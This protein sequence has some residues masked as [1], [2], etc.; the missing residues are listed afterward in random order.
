M[1]WF[2]RKKISTETVNTFLEIAREGINIL[3]LSSIQ[4]I[5]YFI[6]DVV[7]NNQI[8]YFCFST[9]PMAD[10]TSLDTQYTLDLFLKRFFYTNRKYIRQVLEIRLVSSNCIIPFILFL[11]AK[12]GINPSVACTLQYMLDGKFLLDYK[13]G[14]IIK[15]HA[16]KKRSNK[17]EVYK[18]DCNQ[19][20]NLYK[21]LLLSQEIISQIRGKYVNNNLFFTIFWESKKNYKIEHKD[22][23]RFLSLFIKQ[24]QIC[25]ENGVLVKFNPK[26][27]RLLLAGTELLKDYN[28][29][30]L[31]GLFNHS[32]IDIQSLHYYK[33]SEI[34]AFFES[35]FR[36]FVESEYKKAL[37]HISIPF[38]P[39]VENNIFKAI[40]KKTQKNFFQCFTCNHALISYQHLP[41][42]FFLQSLLSSNKHQLQIIQQ[43][44]SDFNLSKSEYQEIKK[45]KE[46]KKREFLNL[47]CIH[48]IKSDVAE[49]HHEE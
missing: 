19:E 35:H 25:D 12:K 20:K 37:G 40:E 22:V 38:L 7:L 21:Y 4:N 31:A 43:I 13:D 14:E 29:E 8:K 17:T 11:M 49:R 27:F 2:I 48:L 15:L 26:H 6:E 28:F 42:L 47:P 34:Q 30:R 5:V 45:I 32:S 16:F 23:S 39:F 36:K 1:H 18:I 10:Y 46:S 24:N 44:I 3:N 9:T 41:F 33:S